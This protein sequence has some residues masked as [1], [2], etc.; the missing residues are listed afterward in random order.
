MFPILAAFPFLSVHYDI[1]AVDIQ[2]I[3]GINMQAVCCDK[4][5]TVI[6]FSYIWQSSNYW[7]IFVR[8]KM[9]RAAMYLPF[10]YTKKCEIPISY[11]GKK[12]LTRG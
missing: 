2:P 7:R 3:S 11:L 9:D 6:G 10:T 4:C 8:R 1:I 5:I 12:G